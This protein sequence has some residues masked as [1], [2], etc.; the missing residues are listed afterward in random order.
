M[1]AVVHHL[2]RHRLRVALLE[3][4]IE[5]LKQLRSEY[6]RVEDLQLEVQIELSGF[7]RL[8][9]TSRDTPVRNV[10]RESAAKGDRRVLAA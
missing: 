7:R 2:N 1:G 10:P 4:E 9:R 8:T 3:T 5:K 6:E